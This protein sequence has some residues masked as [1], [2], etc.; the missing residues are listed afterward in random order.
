MSSPPIRTGA[1]AA[2]A[3]SG[4]VAAALCLMARQ[5]WL[6]ATLLGSG[7]AALV[8][9]V[10]SV[11][12][13]GAVDRREKRPIRRTFGDLVRAGL[14]FLLVLGGGA[15]IWHMWHH[16]SVT[17][18][19]KTLDPGLV[20]TP[21]FSLIGGITGYY[22]GAKGT[23]NALQSATDAKFQADRAR[24]IVGDAL[25]RTKADPGKTTAHLEEAHKQLESLFASP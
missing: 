19:G 8:F 2:G 7:A 14:A 5:G 17:L 23:D 20:I 1:I 25:G 12:I 16:G 18:D 21:V 6:V 9:G 22:F 3:G 10:A 24:R 11:A 13:P 4:L 15:T